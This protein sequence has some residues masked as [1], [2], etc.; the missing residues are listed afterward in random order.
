MKKTIQE[1]IDLGIKELMN[2][3]K[4]SGDDEC[5]IISLPQIEGGENR[6]PEI[7]PDQFIGMKI[8][9][10]RVNNLPTLLVNY[11]HRKLIFTPDEI[12]FIEKGYNPLYGDIH[13]VWINS[14]KTE[15]FHLRFEE[16]ESRDQV[17]SLIEMFRF[18][19]K[20]KNPDARCGHLCESTDFDGKPI[21]YCSEHQYDDCKICPMLPIHRINALNEII[22][23]A[24]DDTE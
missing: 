16:K 23:T 19:K 6:N 12:F 13:I 14:E 21:K 22:E 9:Q 7:K 2:L 15:S 4:K 18:E 1:I 10:S 3:L 17:F 11:Q 20:Q 24:L 8:Y 5:K